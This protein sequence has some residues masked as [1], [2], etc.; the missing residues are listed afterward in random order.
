ML[1]D[2]SHLHGV[3][4]EKQVHITFHSR[5]DIHESVQDHKMQREKKAKKL[6]YDSDSEQ[7]VGARTKMVSH[8]CIKKQKDQL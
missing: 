1:V 8:T 6:T 2:V 4:R 7:R 5:A 3:L